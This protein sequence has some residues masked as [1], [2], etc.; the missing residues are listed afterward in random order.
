MDSRKLGLLEMAL[1]KGKVVP[2]SLEA[3]GSVVLMR[4]PNLSRKPKRAATLRQS[5]SD[6]HSHT[7]PTVHIY[8][9]WRHIPLPGIAK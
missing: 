4:F 8:T 5:H 6:Q 2:G 7:H 3:Y 1:P 9:D